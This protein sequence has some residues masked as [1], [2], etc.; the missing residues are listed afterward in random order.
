M[1]RP[2]ESSYSDLLNEYARRM[3]IFAA[4]MIRNECDMILPFLRQCAEL[5]DKVMIADIQSTDGTLTALREFRDPRVEVQVYEVDR[6]EKYQS[7]L[8]N[9]L[10]R[11]A[12]AQ[13]ADWVF[14]LDADEFL[15]IANREALE[16][17]LQE[18][19][20]DVLVAPWI[21]LVPSQYGSFGTFDPTQTFHWSGRTSRY[22]KVALSSLFVANNPDYFIH[23]GNHAISRSPTAD[24][25]WDRPGPPL[26]HV[27]VRSP[28]Q[29][30]YKI[31]VARRISAAK[32]NRLEGE[33]AHVDELD[34]LLSAGSVEPAELNY[35]AASYGAPLEGRRT[36][37]PNELGW[38]VKRLPAYVAERTVGLPA[39]SERF[40]SFSDTLLADAQTGWD[41]TELIKGTSVGGVIKDTRIRIVPQPVTGGGRYRTG[42]YAALPPGVPADRAPM[43]LLIDVV[44]ISCMRIKAHVFSAWSELIPVMY[45]LFVLLRPRRFV[46][47]GV[48][49]G[50]SFFAACQVAERLGLT[51]ECVAIDSWLGD[52]HAGFHD[53]RVLEEFRAYLGDNYPQQ[54]YIQAYFSAASGCFEDGSIDLLHIDGLH[55]YEAVKEDL[56]TWLPKMSDV[57]VIIFHDINVFERDFGVWRLWEELRRR[58]PAYGFAHQHGLGIIY[59]GSEPHPFAMLLRMLMENHDY[60]TLA[61]ISFQ[62]IGNLLVEHRISQHQHG[63]AALGQQNNEAHSRVLSP[64]QAN[65]SLCARLAS[66]Q[67]DFDAVI[68]STS[69]RA[70]APLRSLLNRTPTLRRIIRRSAKLCWW[71]I[72]GQLVSRLRARRRAAKAA[73]T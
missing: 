13:G 59:V 34:E 22:V 62:T 14:L 55:T 30:K 69:W 6:Q 44:N 66:L 60:A 24:P 17:Y 72:T 25:I 15:D 37:D 8:M 21:N 11:E 12:F 58:Y 40:L 70:T 7:A 36:L 18:T 50:M 26:L 19:G 39:S 43:E 32:H 3:R 4:A 29:L 46:E 51:T 16:R 27:P 63:V 48:H 28:D 57:G 71:T 35:I 20:S 1:D 33:G 73:H 61:Q 9:C 49:N 38:P 45:A 68:H 42:T 31:G 10:S 2:Q 41:H 47:L 64:A 5:F 65:A 56:E 54:E 53:P 67:G 23:E 52:E